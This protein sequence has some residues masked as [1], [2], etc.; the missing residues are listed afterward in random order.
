MSV[1]LDDYRAYFCISVGFWMMRFSPSIVSFSSWYD[2][3]P[4]TG[5][6]LYDSA[7]LSIASVIW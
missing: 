2:N 7:I 3:M 5:L 4:S 6:H 1:K